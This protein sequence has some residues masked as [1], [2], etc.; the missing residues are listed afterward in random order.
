M[1]NIDLPVLSKDQTENISVPIS[2]QECHAA[3]NATSNNKSPGP[4]GFTAEFYKTFWDDLKPS[5]LECV[6]FSYEKGQLP[7]TQKEGIIIML[8]KPQKDLLLPSNYRP[9]TLLNVDYKITA[10]AINNRMLGAVLAVD[11]FKAFDSLKWEFIFQVLRNRRN[12]YIDF[13]RKTNCSGET[14]KPSLFTLAFLSTRLD[15]P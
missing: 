1:S 5:F 7:N 14:P 8:P 11:I 4:D 2:E 3:L 15:Q 13:P 10:S 12:T 6:L 9:I